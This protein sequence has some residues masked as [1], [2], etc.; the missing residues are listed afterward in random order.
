MWM[1]Q[2]HAMCGHVLRTV[3]HSFHENDGTSS[4]N[5]ESENGR[6]IVIVMPMSMYCDVFVI[7]DW[8]ASRPARIKIIDAGKLILMQ[9]LSGSFCQG[10]RMLA[11]TM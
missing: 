11:L 10:L 2:G 6:K 7:L 5:S 3:S 1:V 9:V 8:H 4:F